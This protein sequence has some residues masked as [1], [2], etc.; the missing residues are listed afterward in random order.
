MSVIGILGLIVG[1]TLIGILGAY[2][3]AKLQEAKTSTAFKN[4]IDRIN[5]EARDEIERIRLDEAQ[6]LQAEYMRGMGRI[7]T[8]AMSMHDLP[9]GVYLFLREER[10]PGLEG[11]TWTYQ[12]GR[13]NFFSRLMKESFPAKLD[14]GE[15]S[16]FFGVDEKRR[17]RVGM[18]VVEPSAANDAGPRASAPVHRIVD[19]E[20]ARLEARAA[21]R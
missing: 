6:K 10:L 9:M 4:S 18:L 13:D 11:F 3:G 16:K 17:V 5:G 21:G 19:E 8:E 12:D 20:A 14:A 7:A 2:V 15:K 1:A